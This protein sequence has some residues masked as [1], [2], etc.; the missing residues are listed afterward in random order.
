MRLKK[1]WVPLDAAQPR[2]RIRSQRVQPQNIQLEK[3]VI[4]LGPRRLQASV[5]ISSRIITRFRP[6]DLNASLRAAMKIRSSSWEIRDNLIPEVVWCVFF[7]WI[8][9]GHKPFAQTVCKTCKHVS[10]K[11]TE[12][13]L[14]LHFWWEPLPTPKPTG[15]LKT[16]RP[17]SHVWQI[18]SCH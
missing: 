15:G 4:D 2:H 3:K 12:L 10:G 14:F 8:N 18:Q 7:P 13:F 16:L 9:S 11:K 17:G 6:C 5:F 1:T